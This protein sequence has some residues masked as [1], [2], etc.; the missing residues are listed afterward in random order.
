MKETDGGLDFAAKNHVESEVARRLVL[1]A[2]LQVVV[3]A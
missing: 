2:G 1:Q 3:L